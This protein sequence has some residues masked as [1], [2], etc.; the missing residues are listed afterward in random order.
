MARQDAKVVEQSQEI[1]LG[2]NMKGWIQ[3]KKLTVTVDLSKSLGPSKSGKTTLVAT[4][5]GNT[6]VAVNGEIFQVGINVFK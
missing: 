5:S 6:K 1:V 3:G 4:T 2:N